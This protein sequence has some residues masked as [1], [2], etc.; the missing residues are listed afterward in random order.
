MA[1]EYPHIS[2][3]LSQ[4][5]IETLINGKFDQLICCINN[6]R[7]QLIT[8]HRARQEKRHTDIRARN[9][10]LKQLT[11]SRALLQTELKDNV[12]TS[13]RVRAVEELES[14]MRE[15][16]TEGTEPEVLFECNTH[17]L[18]ETISQLGQLGERDNTVSLRNYPVN[19]HPHISVG[20]R[21]V[22]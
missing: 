4:D 10:T 13:V 8:E 21:G 5:P 20:K 17:Q 7:E 3:T 9:Q 22:A 14:K 18:E 12:L 11:D 15:L 2:P 16:Q 1:E 6:R 19:R